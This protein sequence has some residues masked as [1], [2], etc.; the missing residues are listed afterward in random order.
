MK[1]KK[2]LT[3]RICQKKKVLTRLKKEMM[4]MRKKAKKKSVKVRTKKAVRNPIPKKEGVKEDY[5]KR[6]KLPP[7][8]Y[9]RCR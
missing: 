6:R 8:S 5:L 7:V 4:K 1:K 2:P 3:I 9:G